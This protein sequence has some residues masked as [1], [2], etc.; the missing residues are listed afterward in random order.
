MLV[1]NGKQYRNEAEQVLKNKEDI[2]AHYAM[3]RALANFGIKIVGTVASADDLPDPLTYQGEYGDGY[4]V[5][6]PGSYVYYIYTRPDPNAGQPN[7]YWLNVGSIS[8]VGPEGPRGPQGLTGPQGQSTKWYT[9][10]SFPATPNTNDMFLANNG[11]VYQYTNGNWQPITSIMGPQGVQGIQG[12]QGPQGPIGPQGAQGE[13]GDVGGFINIV[14]MLTSA[15]QLPTP[16]SLDNL[17]YAY[18]VE[19][20]GG[21]DQAND[22]YDLYVQVGE[23]SNV[24]VWLNAGPFNAATLVTVNGEGQNVWNAD[25]KLDKW[26][27]QAGNYRIYGVDTNG[28]TQVMYN[29]NSSNY[30]A[31]IARWGSVLQGT[32][33]NG[34]YLTT[35]TPKNPYHCA[36][37]KYVDE[38]IANN[39]RYF[40]R[41]IIDDAITS[42]SEVYTLEITLISNQETEYTTLGQLFS[43]MADADNPTPRIVKINNPVN[44]IFTIIDMN[45]EVTKQISGSFLEYEA[46]YSADEGTTYISLYINGNVQYITLRG[47]QR[48]VA[49]Q[50]IQL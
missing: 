36:N 37:M 24:A 38:Q 5:G 7:N 9:G 45:G 11:Q 14:G 27:G 3:D 17:T 6:Q 8:V 48:I 22:H 23:N 30:P 35:S 13:R 50:I 10:Q 28:Q 2:A 32:T 41:Y 20:T 18:L 44:Q 29:T 42:P 39:K 40:H 47:E 26:T 21:T 12:I 25:T 33:D 34:G 49:S 1:F 46:E 16:S 43:S 19:H 4:A 31:F 15:E